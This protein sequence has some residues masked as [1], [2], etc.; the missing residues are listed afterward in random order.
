M[1]SRRP[2]A[3]WVLFLEVWT[4]GFERPAQGGL[5]VAG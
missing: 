2:Y 3:R 4:P 5:A 1:V